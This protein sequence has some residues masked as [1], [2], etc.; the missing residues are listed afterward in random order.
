MSTTC[1]L[2]KFMKM[3]GD[4]ILEC[5]LCGWIDNKLCFS[6]CAACGRSACIDCIDKL[7]L[8]DHVL[9]CC[10]HCKGGSELEKFL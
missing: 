6:H 5:K 9:E 2:A 8:D 10:D 3:Y 1:M 4:E 7:G